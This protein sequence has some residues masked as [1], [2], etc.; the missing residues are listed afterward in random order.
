[1]PTYTFECENCGRFDIKLS[2]HSPHLDACPTCQGQVKRIF[3]PNRNFYLMREKLPPGRKTPLQR[4]PSLD[5]LPF[6]W[7]S[8]DTNKIMEQ[9]KEWR[10][11]T[12]N[13]DPEMILNEY[14]KSADEP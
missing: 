3:R 7:Q 5:E 4:V 13:P 14:I 12:T 9:Y 10:W 2:I 1:M 6:D 11:G 8:G